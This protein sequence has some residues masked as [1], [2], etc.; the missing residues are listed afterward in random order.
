MNTTG[1]LGR[2]LDVFMTKISGEILVLYSL[3]PLHF[4][5]LFLFNPTKA[6]YSEV[7]LPQTLFLVES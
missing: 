1:F 6:M 4:I 5:V 2:F 7:Q 3:L